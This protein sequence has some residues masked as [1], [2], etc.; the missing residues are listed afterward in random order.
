[1]TEKNNLFFR[2]PELTLD[3]LPFLLG[4]GRV[5]GNIFVLERGPKTRRL[6]QA[7]AV[8]LGDILRVGQVGLVKYILE[9]LVVERPGLVPFVFGNRAMVELAKYFLR[10]RSGS[11]GSFYGYA[12][13]IWRYCRWIGKSPDEL[14]ADAKNASG[15]SDPQAVQAHVK[16]LESYIAELQDRGLSPGMVANYSKAVKALYRINGVRIDL[17]YS[18]DRKPVVK[19][20]APT[21]EEL[22]RLLEVADLRE[23]VIISLLAL[24]GFREGTLVKLRYRHVREDLERGMVPIHVHVEREITKGKYHDYDTFIGAEAAEFLRLYLEAREKGS[25]DGKM[26]PEQITDESPLIRNSHDHAPKPISAKAV[27]KIVRNLYFKAGLLDK[28]GYVLRA[29][30]LR[31]FF[32]TQ[33]MSLGVQ[34]DYIDYMMGHTV[35][36]YHDIQSKGVEFLRSIYA[37]KSFCIRPQPRLSPI[38]QV[39]AFCRGLG[40]DPEQILAVNAFAEPHRVLVSPEDFERQQAQVL[41]EAIKERLKEEIWADIETQIYEGNAGEAGPSGFEPES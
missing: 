4:L 5:E 10:Y 11:S 41:F 38:E 12:D 14:V 19:D 20:R 23:K 35:D 8:P 21:Q 37:A 29:H 16:A 40:L 32:K 26:P 9:S 13:R 25:P 18:L 24:G 28:G 15:G 6:R 22:C 30:S 2:Q 39:K 36:T 27:R 3:Q 1:M 7:V 31:K 34:P 17:P 33:L